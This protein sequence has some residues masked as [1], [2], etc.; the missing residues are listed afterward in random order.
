MP[1]GSWDA[2]LPAVGRLKSRVAGFDGT[3]P[4]E[5]GFTAPVEGRCEGRETLGLE[6]RCAGREV[7][8]LEGRCAG[9]E[10]LGV[11]GRWAGRD[12]RCGE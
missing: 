12:E 10:T 11:D 4:G 8:G 7:L 6:G 3:R 9:R 1:E 5:G 2:P